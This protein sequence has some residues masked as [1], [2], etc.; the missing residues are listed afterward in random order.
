MSNRPAMLAP[1]RQASHLYPGSI[2]ERPKPAGL[3]VR[4]QVQSIWRLYVSLFLHFQ[5]SSVSAVLRGSV[6]S[7]TNLLELVQ[8]GLITDL[9]F[10]RGAAPVPAGARQRFQNQLLFRLAGSCFRHFF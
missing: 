10:L 9:Q 1:D 4:R 3:P 5:S 8:Q 6:F 2:P 7:V